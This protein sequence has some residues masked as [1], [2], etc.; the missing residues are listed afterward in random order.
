MV[1]QSRQYQKGNGV[2]PMALSGVWGCG[3]VGMWGCGDVG[4]QGHGDTGTRGHRDTGTR[5]PQCWDVRTRGCAIAR[6][7]ARGYGDTE[8]PYPLLGHGGGDVGTWGHEDRDV[9][10]T[11]GT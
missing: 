3:D 10:L 2:A 4:T 5:H 9:I 11:A 1:G 8:V 7:V 6:D